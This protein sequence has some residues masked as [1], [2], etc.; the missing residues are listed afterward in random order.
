M[1]NQELINLILEL[2][3]KNISFVRM[4]KYEDGIL[5]VFSNKNTNRNLDLAIDDNEIVYLI[6][7]DY[8]KVIIECENIEKDEIMNT[9]L[10]FYN[11]KGKK[12]E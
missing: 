8:L 1:N 6:N 7:D 10:K 9:I 12:V 11:K 5:L 3:K 4:A 2:G